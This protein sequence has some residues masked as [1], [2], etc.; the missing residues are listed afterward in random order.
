MAIAEALRLMALQRARDKRNEPGG[1]GRVALL[2]SY[3]PR[4]RAE[5]ARLLAVIVD[6]AGGVPYH[7]AI[8]AHGLTHVEFMLG[9][10]THKEVGLLWTA[11]NEMRDENDLQRCRTAFAK[12]L[13]GDAENPPN[14]KA[15]LAGLEHLGGRKWQKGG[16]AEGAGKGGHNIVYNIQVLHAPRAA[17]VIGAGG[18]CE[19]SARIADDADI[20]EVK[21]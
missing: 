2:E 1:E 19:N 20:I 10:N 14:V 13:E 18:E 6:L 5:D 3:A 21:E 8:A 11:A 15:V 17:A 12:L 4:A 7:D 16:G 9:K